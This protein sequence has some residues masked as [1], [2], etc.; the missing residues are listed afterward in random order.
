M[1]G[2]LIVP[3]GIRAAIGGNAGDA[4]PVAKL[5]ASCCDT[6]ITHPNVVNASD[7]NEMTENTLYVEGSFLN[8]FLQGSIELRRV[9]QNR[10]LVVANPPLRKD[11]I[12]AVAAAEV[13]IGIN[14]EIMEL[15]V[16]L[17]LRA[18][19]DKDGCAD[20]EVDGWLNL[21]RQVKNWD[22][23]ALAIH[24]PITLDREV[25]L[26]YYRNGGVNPWGGV[27]AKASKLIA[28]AL[29]VPV[30]HAPL[31]NTNPDDRELYNIFVNEIVDPTIAPEAISSCYLHCVLKG[32]NKAPRIGNGISVNDVD[33]M[34]SP[35]GCYGP[36]H[37]ACNSRAIPIIVVHENTT[38]CSSDCPKAIIVANYWEAAGVVM[39]MKAGINR[40]SVRS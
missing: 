10:I 13:T 8:R 9:N 4:N 25:A 23:D 29:N 39:C 30:A 40:F 11:T 7:I 31:E 22:F 33:F 38:I 24:T 2:V 14:V 35:L 28:N 21:I 18:K 6:L 37:L 27:E 15:K 3:T 12:N 32:L 19:I 5:I 1:I 36:P 16:P 20:G 26:N 17:V 34:I